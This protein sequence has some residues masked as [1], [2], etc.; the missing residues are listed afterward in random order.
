MDVLNR[1]PV[2]VGEPNE[3][4]VNEI[5]DYKMLQYIWKSGETLWMG[6]RSFKMALLQNVGAVH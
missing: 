1:N 2:D 3:D 5:Q 6:R 4:L